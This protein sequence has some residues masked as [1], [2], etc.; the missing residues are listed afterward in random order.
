MEKCCASCHYQART[1][2][3]YPCKDCNEY[4]EWVRDEDYPPPPPKPKYLYKSCGNCGLNRL[5]EDSV[6]RY[7]DNGYFVTEYT[8]DNCK[9]ITAVKVPASLDAITALLKA[10]Q[11]ISAIKQIRTITGLGLKEAKQFADVLQAY[12]TD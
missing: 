11:K 8:C 3:D 4:S 7:R 12:F 1:D 6:H 9:C 5:L 10:K 2:E